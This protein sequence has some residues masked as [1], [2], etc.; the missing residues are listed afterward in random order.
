L[1]RRVGELRDLTHLGP[2][3]AQAKIDQ[4]AYHA[5][6]RDHN[7]FRRA[8]FANPTQDFLSRAERLRINDQLVVAEQTLEFSPLRL[9][10][11]MA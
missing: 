5:Q 1:P 6:R 11:L 4:P 8:G 2:E 10:R 7:A 9:K 3:R